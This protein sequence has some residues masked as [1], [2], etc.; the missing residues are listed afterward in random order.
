M[1]AVGKGLTFFQ[2]G[3]DIMPISEIDEFDSLFGEFLSRL[4]K[5]SVMKK[6]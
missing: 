1:S 3:D 4:R 5:E 6:N 2:H